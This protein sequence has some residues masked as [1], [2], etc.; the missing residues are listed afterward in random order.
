MNNFPP[1]SLIIYDLSGALEKAYFPRIAEFLD[2]FNYT[3]PAIGNDYKISNLTGLLI[4]A[5]SPSTS[6]YSQFIQLAKNFGRI[7]PAVA[8]IWVWEDHQLTV[9]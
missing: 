4:E 3:L 8:A 5:D 6:F 1:K 9:L 7:F 2:F